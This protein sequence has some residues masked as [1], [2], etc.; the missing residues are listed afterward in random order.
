MHAQT[1]SALDLYVESE[2]WRFESLVKGIKAKNLELWQLK[3]NGGDKAA[4]KYTGDK[5]KEATVPECVV[6]GSSRVVESNCK[7]QSQ[8]IGGQGNAF[9]HIPEKEKLNERQGQT[10]G[11]EEQWGRR[12]RNGSVVKGLEVQRHHILAKYKTKPVDGASK[13][14]RTPLVTHHTWATLMTP[15]K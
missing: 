12:R 1:E 6:A 5:D 3:Q 2:F 9:E 14:P 11:E 15:R 10:E 4:G 7:L 13:T 8:G